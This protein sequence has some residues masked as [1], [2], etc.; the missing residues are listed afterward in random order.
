[1]VLRSSLQNEI[2]ALFKVKRS[3]F[4][5]QYLLSFLD[6]NL[7]LEETAILEETKILN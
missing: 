4:F 7:R 3:D 6:A 2:Y 1:M 5:R